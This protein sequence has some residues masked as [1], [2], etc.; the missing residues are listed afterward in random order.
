MQSFSLIVVCVFCAITASSCTSLPR[1][2]VGPTARSTQEAL[3]LL[4]ASSARAGHPWQRMSDVTVRYNGDWTRLVP[5]LQPVLA[6]VSY[7]K[8][9]TERYQPKARRVVQTHLGPA[10]TKVVVRAGT[11]LSLTRNGILISDT[12]DRAAAALVADAYTVFTIGS[13]VLRACGTGWHIIGER[14]LGGER[15]TLVS[16]IMKPGFGEAASDAV[17]AWIGHETKRLHRVQFT[18]N[19]LATTAGAD[20]DVTFFDFQPGPS[21]TEWPRH[22]IGYVRRPLNLKAHEWRM[23]SLQVVR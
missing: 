11:A 7:R 3:A 18:L 9:S 12:E 13:N 21:G 19:G 22:F 5:K 2:A 16:G 17:I 6:D 1:I 14:T 15:C 4:D 23:T 8:S 20:V 10:G